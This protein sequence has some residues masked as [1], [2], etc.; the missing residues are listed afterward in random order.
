MR[1]SDSHSVL[2]LSGKANRRPLP[3]QPAQAYLILYYAEGTP[4]Y[5][6]IR[7]LY[8]KYKEGDTATIAKLAP[9]L[10]KSSTSKTSPSPAPESSAPT[11]QDN[12]VALQLNTTTPQADTTTSESNVTTQTDADPTQMG[13]DTTPLPPEGSGAKKT[14]SRK[15][16]K[17]VVEDNPPPTRNVPKFVVFQQAIVREKI[18][19]MSDIESDAVDALIEERYA[20][21]VAAWESPWTASKAGQG[22]VSE[23]E[24]ENKFYQEYVFPTGSIRSG[25]HFPQQHRQTW[26]LHPGCHRGNMSYHDA[27]DIRLVW[28][29]L[30]WVRAWSRY[31][32]FHC[33]RVTNYY[34]HLTLTDACAGFGPVPLLRGIKISSHSWDPCSASWRPSSV[35][36]SS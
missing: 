6:E 2:D 12:A 3:L 36:G 4:L 16:K 31:S 26:T 7:A 19:T 30:P 29:S 8:D 32:R 23:V 22:G 28:R 25:P 20:A 34:Y 24:L 18:K 35:N 9:L 11:P 1:G 33:I 10:A 27:Q 17:A 5:V 21:A 15:R 13:S 14:R